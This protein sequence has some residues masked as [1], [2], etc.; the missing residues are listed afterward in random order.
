MGVDI[1][2]RVGSLRREAEVV[3]AHHERM[4]GSGYPRALKGESIP[5][6]ARIIAVADT[7]DVLISDRPYRR[8]HS[9][10][11]AIGILQEE[12]GSRLDP[13]VVD[14]LLSL[15]RRRHDLGEGLAA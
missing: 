10:E 8:A 15:L 14:A 7:Y 6:L 11:R 13:R 2:S 3:G 4:D 5:L 12:R 9:P 1:L